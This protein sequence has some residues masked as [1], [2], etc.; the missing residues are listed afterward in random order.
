MPRKSKPPRLYLEDRGGRGKHWVIRDN[1]R[2]IRTGCPEGRDRDAEKALS[3]YIVDKHEISG[4][5]R[6]AKVLIADVLLHYVRHKSSVP[7]TKFC[8]ARLDAF[9]ESRP[10]SDIKGPLCR[11]YLEARE[12]AG[13]TP[14]TVRREL[15]VLQAALNF[16]HKEYGLDSVPEVSLPPEGLP[17]DTWMTREQF[18]A[19]LW[20]AW[21]RP[22]SRHLARYMLIAVYSGTRP[23]A[24][25]KLRWL[26]S[27]VAG[28][29]DVEKGILYRKGSGERETKKRRPPS[30]IHFRL[31]AHMRRWRQQD[32]AKGIIHVIHFRGRPVASIRHSWSIVRDEAGLDKA[33]V[34]YCL[35]HTA[36]TWVMQRGVDKWEAAGYL[37]ISAEILE[38][39]YAHHHPDFQKNAAGMGTDMG[40]KRAKKA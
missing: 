18:A 16:Y 29:V 35:K 37:G 23:A 33:F 22:E 34:P 5:R 7:T 9:F 20:T 1:G 40:Q 39:V 15:G 30:R 21:R 4:E 11:K 38:N 28:Q 25:T 19:M 17:R 10:V 36:A 8:I 27:P 31:L 12:R 6:T 2:K 24:I 13:V 14:A 26:P 3:Q 32:L